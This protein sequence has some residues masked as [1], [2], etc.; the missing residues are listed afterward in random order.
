MKQRK[1]SELVI[2]AAVVLALTGCSRSAASARK[3][4]VS[5]TR[6]S[7]G[8]YGIKVKSDRSSF[9]VETCNLSVQDGKMTAALTVRGSDYVSIF[10]GA[11]DKADESGRI[12]AVPGNGK[13]TFLIPVR[14][15]DSN[16]SC[17]V[18]NDRTKKWDPVSLCFQSS[19]LPAGALKKDTMKTIA[20]LGL[21]D[22]GYFVDAKLSGG[23]GKASVASPA[24]LTVS[25]GKA[26]LKVEFSSSSFNSMTVD[27]RKYSPVN[28]GGNSVFLIPVEELDYEMPVAADT[29]A[30]SKAHEIE[31]TIYLDSTTIRQTS[32]GGQS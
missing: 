26:V 12:G 13:E 25:G 30:M 6:V 27:G 19:S 21:S 22:G 32:N 11:P 24:V 15:L 23:S 2:L 9:S 18:F 28:S 17:A 8:T 14:V 31:Y 10:M 1:F 20:E 29:T 16:L 7:D 4:P 3:V 5:G